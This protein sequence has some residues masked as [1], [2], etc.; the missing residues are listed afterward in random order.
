MANNMWIF[1]LLAVFAGIHE[2]STQVEPSFKYMTVYMFNSNTKEKAK[3]ELYITSYLSDTNV[4][5]T[6][7]GSPFKKELSMQGGERVTVEVP[8]DTELIGTGK[9]SKT[10]MIQSNKF[11]TIVSA[12]LKKN[13]YDTSL[14]YPVTEW[15]QEYYIFTPAARGYP[16]EFAVFGL[17][18]STF[19]TVELTCTVTFEGKTYKP[20][21]KLTTHIHA[22]DVLY[23]ESNGDNEDCT[24]SSVVSDKPVGVISGHAC[25]WKNSLCQHVFEQLLPVERWGSYFIVPPLEYQVLMDS[26]FIFA[27]KP[28]RVSY[29][30]GA[31]SE[32][33][34]LNGG[35]RKEILMDRSSPL[36]ISST[37]PVQ[38]LYYCTGG[39]FSDNT[40][41][42]P[43]LTNIE[44]TDKFCE[45]RTLEGMEGVTNYALIVAKTKDI[46]EVQFDDKR[47]PFKWLQVEGTE[48]SWA[49]YTYDKGRSHHTI[50]SPHAPIGVYSVGTVD[51]N[52]YGAPA[53]CGLLTCAY[54]GKFYPAGK[55]FWDDSACTELCECNPSTGSVNCQKSQCKVGEECKVVAGVSTC[56]ATPT[57]AEPAFRYITVYMFNSN[58]KEKATNE[59]YITSYLS[60]TKVVVTVNKSPFKKELSMQGGERVTVEVPSDTELIGT[61]KY[62]KTVIIQSNRYITIVSTNRKK[63]TLDTTL[64]YPLTEFGQEYYIFT[65]LARG[66]PKEFAVFGLQ[67]TTLVTVELKCTVTFEGK[68]YKPNE[69]L[70]AY[71]NGLEV[72]YLESNGDNEDCTGSRVVSDKPVGVIS[73]HACAW[74]NSLCQ[75]AFEQLLPVE[76]WGTYFIVP[77]L[78]YQVLMDS[79]FIFAYK[80]THVIYQFG[81]KS[82]EIDL[83]SGQWK[84]I[85]MDRS[86]PLVI[87]S[88][89]PIQ[90]LYYCTGGKFSDNT[91]FD[92][93]IMNIEPTD[94]FCESRTLEG[95]EDFTN[96]ALIVAKTSD[97]NKVIFDDKHPSFKWLKVEG[98]EYSWAHYTYDKGRS[99][100]T[101]KSPHAPIGVYS[102]GTVDR[103]SYGAPA[104][105][106]LLTC[107]YKGKSYLPDERF[108]EDSA[109]T[110]LCECNPSTGFVDCQKSECKAGEECKVIEGHNE[111]VAKGITAPAYAGEGKKTQTNVIVNIYKFPMNKKVDTQGS[112]SVTVEKGTPEIEIHGAGKYPKTTG[113][114][115][116]KVITITG[117]SQVKNSVDL[118]L[119]YPVSEWGQD[120]YVFTPPAR[121]YQKQLAV[122]S[123]PD[124][125]SVSVDLSCTVS[126]RGETYNP[127]D[128]LTVNLGAS[129][130]VYLQSDEDCT[131]SRV[132][133]DKPIGVISGHAC[134]LNSKCQH[135]LKQLLPVNQWGTS[136]IIPP[137]EYQ[138]L[139]DSVY[140]FA[141]KPTDVT[142][143]FGDKSQVINLSAGQWKA[144]PMGKNTPLVISSTQPI[145]VLYYCNGG[146]FSDGS[147]F[148]PFI[149]NI[150]PTDK[151]C[152]A[153]VLGDM[154][155]LNNYA[156]IVANTKD[157]NEVQFDN[158]RPSFKWQQVQGTEYSWAPYT[159]EKGNG[160]HIVLHPSAPIRVY[161]VG[162]AKRNGYG[163]PA[164]CARFSG[165]RLK[166]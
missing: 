139:V 55:P 152:Q 72:L 17:E 109:C 25:A 162:T 125:S 53:A 93:F 14:V 65:P 51:R 41:F 59:L 155:G 24:G 64:V 156:L 42:D 95:M 113:V 20:N 15:G 104:A 60:D 115:T 77:P 117:E 141:S 108:W 151:F 85:Q 40:Q 8:S 124:A 34:D 84:E 5:V 12:N 101:M 37:Q 165:F 26:V 150:V 56:V 30:L 118:S 102:V 9:Y 52:S 89:L 21:E 18:D 22:S 39:K 149:M 79:V 134:D 122:F 120:Y 128:K 121:G 136:Y 74:K 90:V 69:K 116:N 27:Y 66:Y 11:I 159:Y 137:L 96:Y 4:V 43:F 160:H 38:V 61:G 161:S 1:V 19:V 166:N 144:L 2:C 67:D 131:G 6:V 130:I 126:F 83:R 23:L 99:H 82:Q 70:Y 94:K 154:D 87:S 63:N 58:A 10:V 35:Q 28:T 148:D 111:C 142:Y 114:Q 157:I 127:H 46:K 119:E 44:P 138:V 13:S 97:I 62:S 140:I 80:P 50:K 76:R 147:V 29:K 129:E 32:N 7:N 107:T 153:N 16:K 146:R 132:V 133:S 123:G 36:I 164:S 78:E 3:N 105:C 48:Y 88:T 158:K 145:Q 31:K 68:T 86:S 110:Q 106:G 57:E 98:T 49:H 54:K 143:Q 73:G 91:V 81:A 100:H 75:H 112:K 71:I 163:A 45:S 92:P 47:P 135:T 33:I 103:N